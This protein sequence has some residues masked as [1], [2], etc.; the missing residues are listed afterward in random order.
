M[1]DIAFS[2]PHCRQHLVVDAKGAGHQI[3][4]P[5]CD[6][7]VVVPATFLKRP[8]PPPRQAHKSL[9][10]S[11]KCIDSAPSTNAVQGAPGAYKVWVTCP[12][13]GCKNM[14]I[15]CFHC[16]SEDKFWRRHNGAV[17]YCGA[18]TS[19][20]WCPTCQ[21]KID[22]QFF[23]AFIDPVHATGETLATNAVVGEGS[24]NE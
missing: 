11:P 4:C 18:I 14:H 20:V 16:G 12:G 7:Q 2:C 1:P 15:K 13:C 3:A 9:Q 5:R 8:A 6:R 17:C 21:T 19:L 24:K 10:V 23:R 22:R